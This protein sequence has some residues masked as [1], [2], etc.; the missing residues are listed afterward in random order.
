M[1]LYLTVYTNFSSFDR[2]YPKSIQTSRL[3]SPSV[4]FDNTAISIT[5]TWL[6]ILKYIEDIQIPHYDY[7]IV[8]PPYQ[9]H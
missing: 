6:V 2:K 3:K 5:Q 4:G 8:S 1:L 7:I 9:T